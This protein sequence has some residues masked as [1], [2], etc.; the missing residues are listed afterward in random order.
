[1]LL[2][3]TLLINVLCQVQFVP[4][5][6]VAG[7]Q[8]G[9]NPLERSVQATF[10]EIYGT[11]GTILFTQNREITPAGS[12][13]SQQITLSYPGLQKANLNVLYGLDQD[14]HLVKFKDVAGQEFIMGSP[15]AGAQL[16]WQYSTS[17]GGFQ[18]TF[19]LTDSMPIGYTAEYGKFFFDDRGYLMTNYES[20][21][22]F[23]FDANGKLIVDGPDQAAYYL[24][25]GILYRTN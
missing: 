24:Q 2:K 3:N 1:M 8:N 5:A 13:Y 6:A 9:I 21:E 23:Y 17:F 10:N 18:I 4:L 16:T 14:Q 19:D 7:V 12:V 20:T 22:T 25:N 11:P 15:D